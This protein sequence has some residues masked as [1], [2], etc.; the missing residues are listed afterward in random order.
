MIIP[1]KLPTSA[2]E[3]APIVL[4]KRRQPVRV[5]GVGEPCFVSL[6]ARLRQMPAAAGDPGIAGVGVAVEIVGLDRIVTRSEDDPAGP[7]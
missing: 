2:G 4:L 3:F 7:P 5:R 6:S 1:S